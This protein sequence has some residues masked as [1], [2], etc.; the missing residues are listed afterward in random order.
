[1][2]NQIVDV[3]AGAFAPVLDVKEK[4]MDRINQI[5]QHPLFKSYMEA[6]AVWEKERVFCK[7]NMAHVLD[8]A[9]IAYILNIEE[10]YQL[11]KDMI[12][13]A[14]LLHDIGRHVQYETGEKHAFV[15]AGLA[16]EIL[17]DCGYDETERAEIV[18]AIYHHSDKS[19]MARRDLRGLIARAD[20]L[21]RACY[22]C[23][24]EAE[25]NW[26]EAR[27]NHEIEW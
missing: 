27:K 4:Y 26:G 19:L 12:Y 13:G 18:D 20:R 24:V 9:R 23:P 3:S 17:A 1:M 7:H 16:P 21:S 2:G 6:N 22:V 8:V 5:L 14:A 15:S 25:C 11:S 10:A